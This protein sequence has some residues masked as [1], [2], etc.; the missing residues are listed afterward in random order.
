MIH[1]K[2]AIG[3]GEP[4]RNK[5][6]IRRQRSGELHTFRAQFLEDRPDHFDFLSPEIAALA[7]MRIETGDQNPRR[8]DAKPADEFRLEDPDGPFEAFAGKR[9][10]HV[11]QREVRG[12]KRDAQAPAREHHDHLCGTG[13]L[14]EILRM[15]D[16]RD[17]AIVDDALVHGCSRE[18]GELASLAACNCAVDERNHVRRIARIRRACPTGVRKRDM[19]TCDRIRSQACAGI[20]QLNA[21]PELPGATLEHLPVS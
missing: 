16:E 10:R 9:A 14:G 6:R 1:R 15:S 12:R 5:Q 8:R 21:E 3:R 19:Q 7:A 20:A 2:Y 17:A 18:R 11:L 13:A 4:I